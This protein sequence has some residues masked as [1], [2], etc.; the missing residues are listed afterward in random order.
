V[1]RSSDRD[2]TNSLDA[3]MVP[4]RRPLAMP[5]PL[6]HLGYR[7]AKGPGGAKVLE[8][9][10]RDDEQCALH[11]RRRVDY[12]ASR[13]SLETLG[14]PQYSYHAWDSGMI[15]GDAW[16]A[17]PLSLSERS[18]QKGFAPMRVEDDRQT[19][20]EIRAMYLELNRNESR[21]L[22]E[23]FK[24]MLT[25]HG[26]LFAAIGVAANRE[27]FTIAVLVAIVGGLACIPW[28]VSVRV[29]YRGADEIGRR[30]A[31]LNLQREADRRL[32]PIDAVFVRRSEFLLL[33]EVVLPFVVGVTWM[34]IIFYLLFRVTK[35]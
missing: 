35:S 31:E 23:R 32:P 6:S 2:Y 7:P 5:L 22:Y 14:W 20:S 17:G 9:G 28:W 3:L 8:S 30:F 33:P 34:A 1:I 26:L 21:V 11:W 16:R 24:G 29:S 15:T 25:F 27:Y 10:R 18:F 13:G 4:T 19:L 12:P